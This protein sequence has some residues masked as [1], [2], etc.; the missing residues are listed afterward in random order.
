M[1]W[2]AFLKGHEFD[3]Y[4]LGAL[5][6]SG[7]T[8]VIKDGN[9]YFLA[10]IE[11][12]Q[13]PPG[14]EF[15]NAAERVLALV[16]GVG[17]ANSSSFRP[18]ALVGRFQEGES[19][20][21]HVGFAD[22]AEARGYAYAAAVLIDPVGNEAPAPPPPGAERIRKA[23]SDVDANE[24]LR[25]MGR[26]EPTTWIDLFKVYEIVREAL[27]VLTTEVVDVRRGALIR[28]ETSGRSGGA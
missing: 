18:V 4:E 21:H 16:N 3:L 27:G 7:D 10:S 15:Y 19:N 8:Q 28:E 12:D 17:Q 2:K 1:I 9:D 26:A 5:F 22:T 14:E 13:R 23:M 25:I 6:S 24:A 11:I 20:H